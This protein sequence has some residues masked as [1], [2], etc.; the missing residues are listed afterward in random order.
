MALAVGLAAIFLYLAL[1][2]VDWP[3]F[4][5]SLVNG[6]YQYLVITIPMALLEL[7]L[8]SMRWGVL[9]R[10]EK[11][12]PRSQIFWSNMVGYMGNSYLPARA[13][14]VLRSFAI[15]RKY[16]FSPSFALATALTERVVDVIVLVLIS[17][18]SLLSIKSDSEV[19]STALKGVAGV[20]FSGLL[21]ILV[22]P[23]LEK[24]IGFLINHLPIPEKWKIQINS[25]LNLFLQGMGTLQNLRRLL[26]FLGFTIMIW[27]IDGIGAMI[28]ANLVSSKL[29]L[30]QSLLYLSALGLSSAIPST[31]G[32]VGVY[33][34]VAV[35]VL[36][37]FGF[38]K[39]NAL[40][41]VLISQ[42]V[43]YILVGILGLAGL[44]QLKTKG[45]IKN[46][47]SS[48]ASE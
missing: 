27:L 47:L 12:I 42:V 2:D 28:G 44:W 5:L 16:D 17:S 7:F 21:V 30:P 32:Y 23:K 9:L 36:V 33:Q 3:A 43:N 29:T 10:A 19:F 35:T 34:F 14:E 40:A 38:S 4:W 46:T 6:Q 24:Q 26:T 15:S 37:P 20:A 8:R 45:I 31:P 11:K 25:Q 39:N 13:G 18:I 22:S 41:F 48:N 1:R